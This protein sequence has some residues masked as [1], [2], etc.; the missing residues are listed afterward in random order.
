MKDLLCVRV[1]LQLG[2]PWRATQVE[3]YRSKILRR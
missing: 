2:R 3:R 1:S